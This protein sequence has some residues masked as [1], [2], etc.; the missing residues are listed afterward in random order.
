M[1]NLL[2]TLMAILMFAVFSLPA[3]PTG[4]PFTGRIE[5]SLIRG[6]ETQMLIFTAGTNCLRIERAETDRPYACNLIDR[7]T[8]EVTLLYPQNRSF[9]RLS[10]GG[11]ASSPARPEMPTI[12]KI[13]PEFGPQSVRPQ[14]SPTPIVPTN[15][16]SVVAPVTMPALPAMGGSIQT[17]P[18]MP[19]TSEPL[20]L[21]TAED[22][23]NLLG[24][25]CHH[26]ELKQ[27]GEIMEIW[28]AQTNLP[29][30]QYL[31][32]QPTRFGPRMIEEQWAGFVAAKRLFP[33]RAVLKFENGPER[34][35][36]EVRSITPQKPEEQ[37]DDL[38]RPPADYH[39]IDSLPF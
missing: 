9:V 10:G 6:G 26:Y 1:N 3:A 37:S 12:P 20:E 23:T 2:F 8:G 19:L 24:V 13:L 33:F 15:L 7:T 11:G 4:E 31:P 27:R 14:M 36:Y 38:F 35:R 22:D 17:R 30:A 21:T 34:L 28:A 18:M 32:N 5:A 39:Q 29:F 16:P 25:A